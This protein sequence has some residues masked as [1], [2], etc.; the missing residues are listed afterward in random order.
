MN[1][2]QLSK[3]ELILLLRSYDEYIMDIVDDEQNTI[4]KYPVCVSE[5]YDNE[6]QEIVNETEVK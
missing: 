2:E 5:F 3:D 6:F 1:Y 4:N